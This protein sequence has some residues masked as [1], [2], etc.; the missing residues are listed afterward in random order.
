MVIRKKAK[1]KPKTAT[2]R[3]GKA[4]AGK[5]TWTMYKD[6]VEK[7]LYWIELR[8]GAELVETSEVTNKTGK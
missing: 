7:G 8:T 1:P 6:K 2:V 4:V 5:G 3:L